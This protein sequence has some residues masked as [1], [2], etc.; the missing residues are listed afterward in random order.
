[1]KRKICRIILSSGNFWKLICLGAFLRNHMLK[2]CWG[3]ILSS[4]GC[5]FCWNHN[6]FS[7]SP[8]L[9]SRQGQFHPSHGDGLLG[10][11]RK[12]EYWG[13]Y[14]FHS[15]LSWRSSAMSW[16]LNINLLNFHSVVILLIIPSDH[17]LLFAKISLNTTFLMKLWGMLTWWRG[18]GLPICLS[19]PHWWAPKQ[20]QIDIQNRVDSFYIRY[21]RS[22]NSNLISSTRSAILFSSPPSCSGTSRAN[23]YKVFFC[24]NIHLKIWLS[25]YQPGKERSRWEW[26][27]GPQ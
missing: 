24:T 5:I 10:S 23:T 8:E 3:S 13:V 16:C 19:Q 14:L 15:G 1:M 11:L 2:V 17:A 21:V 6:A 26:W 27:R 25:L 7:L 12:I 4:D 22:Y 18:V 9:Y 20:F